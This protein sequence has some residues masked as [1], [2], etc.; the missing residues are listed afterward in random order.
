M[1]KIQDSDIRLAEDVW[2]CMDHNYEN[3][4]RIL[5][6]KA[7]KTNEFNNDGTEAELQ[8]KQKLYKNMGADYGTGLYCTLKLTDIYTRSA[9]RTAQQLGLAQDV[10]AA[11]AHVLTLQNKAKKNT[12]EMTQN[13]ID[14]LKRYQMDALAAVLERA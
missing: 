5:F 4:I 7:G 6:N 8:E 10:D 11:F 12:P 14:M 13:H 1:S 9:R 3:G 2:E